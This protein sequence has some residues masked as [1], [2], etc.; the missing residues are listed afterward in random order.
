MSAAPET[1]A[2]EVPRVEADLPCFRCGYNLRTLPIDGVCTECGTGVSES[3]EYHRRHGF[4][5]EPAKRIR[6]GIALLVLAVFMFFGVAALEPPLKRRADWIIPMAL[7]AVLSVAAVGVVFSTGDTGRGRPRSKFAIVAR[8]LLVMLLLH[9]TATLWVPGAPEWPDRAAGE[10][11][12]LRFWYHRVATPVMLGLVILAYGWHLAGIAALLPRRWL[13][14]GLATFTALLG[15]GLIIQVLLFGLYVTTAVGRGSPTP[16]WLMYVAAG[17]RV[18]SV[19]G[20]F[21]W[22]ACVAVLYLA[23]RKSVV[24]GAAKLVPTS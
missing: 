1:T 14:R 2:P 11:P 15:F 19:F 3:I 20:G 6:R 22:I 17:W 24:R 8:V 12:L 9:L 16:V 18:V 21:A 4:D 23:L 7:A 13:A 10:R 5:S